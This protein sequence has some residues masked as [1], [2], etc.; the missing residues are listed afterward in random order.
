MSPALSHEADPAGAD[1]ADR[2][3]DARRNHERIVAAAVEVFAER[4]L[5]ATV[6]EVAARAGVGKA[7][8]YRS[9]PT[10]ADLVEA[11]ARHRIT[12]LIERVDAAARQPDAFEA[13]RSLLID[14]AERLASDRFLVEVLPHDQRWNGQTRSTEQFAGLVAAAVEQ[15]RLRPDATLQ[16]IRVLVGGY[17]R[18][19]LD[20]GIR[21][22]AQWRR[23]AAL[24]LDALRT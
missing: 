1:W 2:R 17:S 21:D 18:V 8:V 15:G 10:K 12:W 13:L 16:D 9:Y 6:P 11:V 19:L 20:L 5:E 14:I 7:T 4:G 3:A 24:A 23:Y 22:P